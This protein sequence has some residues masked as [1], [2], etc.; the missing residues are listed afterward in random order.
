M[1]T[2][3]PL[4]RAGLERVLAEQGLRAGAA[5][6]ADVA[7][8]DLRP[9]KKLPSLSMD[10]PL[11]VLVEAGAR[12]TELLSQGAA[13]VLPRDCAPER[14]CAAI[15]AVG[16]GLVVV[17]GEMARG[18]LPDPS[19]LEDEGEELTASE[20]QVLTL[21][22]SGHSNRRVAKA[23]GISEHTAKFFVGQI[24]GK[25]GVATRTEAVVVA[26]RRGLLWL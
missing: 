5:D 2:H 15:L 22:A 11:V 21:V 3:D 12:P 26:A 23:L 24:L 18:A 10:L 7:V 19:A 6:V 1:V 9:G 16:L 8:V 13:A 4:V 17:D 25:L 20:R 14:L